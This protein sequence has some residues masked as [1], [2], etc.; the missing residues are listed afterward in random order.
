MPFS[1][2]KRENGNNMETPGFKRIQPI[3]ESHYFSPN[4]HFD[5]GSF[6]EKLDKIIKR[7]KR[8]SFWSSK[9]TIQAQKLLF[10]NFAELSLLK[11]Y[12]S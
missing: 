12:D 7:K 5:I 10:R 11:G 9:M 2:K 6:R 4:D 1:R 8:T 3:Y